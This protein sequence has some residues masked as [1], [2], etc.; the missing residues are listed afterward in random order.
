M[1][2]AAAIGGNATQENLCQPV[3]MGVKD[4]GSDGA[5]QWRAERL[6][7]PDGLRPWCAAQGLQWDSLRSQ[8]LFTM[9]ELDQPQ[10]DRLKV[11]LK[12]GTK[13]LETLTLNFC[14]VFE[15]PSAAGREAD[16]RIAYAHACLSIMMRDHPAPAPTQPG[17]PTMPT[18]IEIVVL[19][20]LAKAFA[21]MIESAVIGL[22]KGWVSHIPGGSV[23]PTGM[24]TLDPAAVA[25]MIEDAL[26]KFQAGKPA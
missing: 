13:S 24:V 3:T 2:S 12:L 22:I 15:R 9:H 25:K 10:Y 23:T 21:P 5:L 4:H 20:Q 18:S 8:A 1:R 19:E 26:A 6:D 11:D 17:A 14:D 16:N 7:G